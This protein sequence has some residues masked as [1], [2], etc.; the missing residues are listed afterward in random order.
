LPV[1]VSARSRAVLLSLAILLI[2]FTGCASP[3]AGLSGMDTPTF[4]PQTV[5]VETGVTLPAGPTQSATATPAAPTQAVPVHLR[6][7]VPDELPTQLITSLD[8]PSSIQR[9]E[10]RKDANLWLEIAPAPEAA[11]SNT[12]LPADSKTQLPATSWI[13]ALAAPFPTVVDGVRLADVQKAWKGSPQSKFP[14][15]PLL[16]TPETRAVFETWWGPADPDGVRVVDRAFL[17]E[18]AWQ[19]QPAWALLPFEDIEP[20]WKVLQVDGQS[21]LQNTF[22]PQK[23][24]LAVPMQLNGKPEVLQRLPEILDLPTNRD[25]ARLTVLTMTGV[26]ALARHIAQAM[27]KEGVLYPAREIGPWLSG[28]DL[29]HISNEVSFYTDC[30]RPGPQRVDMRFCSNP[31]YIQL[32]EAVGTDIVE[33]TGNHNL[34]WGQPAFLSSL[35]MYRQRGW[36][37]YGGG[38]H[39]KEA[40]T[41]LLIEHNGNRLAFLGCSPA[42]PEP[43]WATE[44]EPGSAPCN[45]RRLEEQIRELRDAGYPPVVS[46]Q[47]VE[48][49]SYQPGVAQGPPDF[50]RLAKAGAVIV[51]GSQSHYPQTMTFILPPSAAAEETPQASFVHYGLGNLFFDQMDRIETRQAFIDRHVFYNGKYLGVELLTTLLEDSAWPRLMTNTE[52]ADFLSEIFSLSD[53]SE[54]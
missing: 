45:W 18:T 4:V 20:R 50:R 37:V 15:K 13:Y 39:L 47:H 14:K 19:D 54:Q 9:V 51:S 8:L 16:M 31:D 30:P 32:L 33:L 49:E 22:E 17:L 53:W 46:L 2:I 35:E 41:P 21:P 6:L 3:A 44:F 12:Q 38:A 43:V 34:D 42:G 29:T 36:K 25:P 40:Q 23:Y 26:T 48:T 28:A 24:P 52:R 7:W 10:E 11:D 27:E 5:S 1:S